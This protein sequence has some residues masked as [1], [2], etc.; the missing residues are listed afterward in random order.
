[1]GAD[2]ESASPLVVASAAKSAAARVCEQQKTAAGR[3]WMET[4]RQAAAAQL[5]RTPATTRLLDD[6]SESKECFDDSKWRY[7]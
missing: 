7:L 2:E 5:A 3:C 4:K 6:E 1:L